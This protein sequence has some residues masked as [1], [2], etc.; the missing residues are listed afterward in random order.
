MLH[1]KV[2]T[3]NYPPQILL[4]VITAYGFISWLRLEWYMSGILFIVC[5][6]QNI[7]WHTLV[8]GLSLPIFKYYLFIYYFHW[9][10]SKHTNILES[11]WIKYFLDSLIESWGLQKWDYYTFHGSGICPNQP[12]IQLL[13]SSLFLLGS[14]LILAQCCVYVLWKPAL[15]PQ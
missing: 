14:Q 4:N 2:G 10:Y 7:G 8:I 11:F 9:G 6:Y 15:I 13:S 1:Q 5:F 12:F 3:N